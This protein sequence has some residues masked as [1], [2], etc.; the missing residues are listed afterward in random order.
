MSRPSLTPLK[1]HE[2]EQRIFKHRVIIAGLIV[3]LAFM[4]L[5]VRYGYL[6]IFEYTTYSTLAE[7][8]RVKLQAIAPPRGY[9]YDRNG[10][11]L[12]DNRPVFTAVINR[13]EIKD[14]EDTLTRIRPI[15]QLTDEDILRF[16]QRLKAAHRYE[17]IALKLNLNEADIAR[18]AEVR[19]QFTGVDIEAKLARY[20]P[21]GELFAHVLGY[22]GRIS[23]KEANTIDER[24]YAGTDLI[25]KTGLE[26]YYEDLLQGRPGYQHI[27]ANAHGQILRLLDRTPP[28]RGHDLTL[29]LD[30][31]L[32]KLIHEQLAGRRG[33]VVAIEPS[34]GGIL[35]FVSNPS[36]DPNPFVNGV[37]KSL[38]TFWRDHP[39]KPL[40]NR[41][42]QG[43]YP[44]GSTIKPFEG[45]GGIHYGLVDWDYKIRDP[46]F[47][48]LP[49]DSHLFRDWK[50]TGHGIVNLHRAVEISCDTYFYQLSSRMGVDRF[51]D[52]MQQFG[53]GQPTGVDL[54]GEKSGTLPSVAWKRK[55]LK[56]PWYAGEML[57][58][59]IGQGYFTATP[60][61][62]AMA[63]AI[64]ANKGQHIRPH[65][66]KADNNAPA[67]STLNQPDGQVQFS[68]DPIHW[69]LMHAAMR[70]VVHG[71]GTAGNLRRDLT[72]YEIAGKTG[73]AQVKGIKQG[74]RYNE[75]ALDERHWD[76]AWF[77]G[78][79]PVINPQVA[80]AVLVENGKHGNSAAGPI[81]KAVF[82][83]V[84]HQM[85]H[86]PTPTTSSPAQR[87]TDTTAPTGDE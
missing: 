32:Q 30:Y 42:L 75:K 40:Y 56:A 50:K 60:L 33:A 1:D 61:Q 14:I 20:Y 58:V 73:T 2:R 7:S 43:I 44:P 5:I 59:G 34:T 28:T 80:V 25:G 27:E 15:F 31:G 11:L 36:F 64:T 82:D 63:T 86:T 18:F 38:Y 65:L 3:S 71:R 41:A 23:E 76:H 47:Y 57:S 74:E 19:F 46:G 87:S 70:D 4:G 62:L 12:A 26:K 68:G 45:L 78:F 24:I 55:A 9:I 83:Y 10:I 13:Q 49:G 53:F 72:G 37:P 77:V 6:Q 69:D 16:R 54:V 85:N 8:N 21:Y 48:H 81:A 39:D 17:S 29:H 79:A 22:V 35:A 52:W 66:L 84:I 67:S 51:H